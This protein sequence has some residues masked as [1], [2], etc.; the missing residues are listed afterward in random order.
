MPATDSQAHHVEHPT[1]LVPL[2]N[3]ALVEHARERA[4]SAQNR[5]AD[6]ITAFAGSMT[7]VYIHIIWFALLDRLRRR[8]L[9]VRPADDDRLAR[10]DL[11]LDLRDDQPEPRRREASSPCRP[12]LSPDPRVDETRPHHRDRPTGFSA[13]SAR[14]DSTT[15]SRDVGSTGWCRVTPRAG[16]GCVDAERLPQRSTRGVDRRPLALRRSS[17]GPCD[18]RPVARAR[19]TTGGRRQVVCVVGR[20]APPDPNGPH[21]GAPQPQRPSTKL[22]QPPPLGVHQQGDC[23]QLSACVGRGSGWVLRGSGLAA[24]RDRVESTHRAKGEEDG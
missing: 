15:S 21:P 2:P 4:E 3:P 5:L 13:T 16:R 17:P 14:R 23:R 20:A 22:R 12:A 18:A 8:E 1:R 10:G 9:P 6:R 7:F 19:R 24:M 11:P